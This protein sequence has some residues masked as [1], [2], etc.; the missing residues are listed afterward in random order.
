MRARN[1]T[2]GI[3]ALIAAAL[4]VRLGVWQM[5][6][7][8]ERRAKNA[9]L[10]ER[11]NAAPVPLA[12][13]ALDTAAARFRRVTVSGNLDYEHE[14]ALVG[15]ALNGSP[16]VYLVTPLRIDDDS[17]PSVLVNRGWVYSPDARVV[18]LTRWHEPSRVTVAGY[19]EE[20][21]ADRRAPSREA[22]AARSIRAMNPAVIAELVPYPVSPLYI[23]AQQVEPAV[24]EQPASARADHPVRLSLPEMD[25]GPHK[26]YAIQWFS[27]AVIALVG[28]STLIWHDMHKGRATTATGSAKG[29]PA[30]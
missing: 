3:L 11:L 20:F 21:A 17:T 8:A 6:R 10:A 24:R 23:V 15:R 19:L 4:F 2:A 16:G 7:L 18:D 27:F 9:L 12:S 5:H 25:E 29:S 13:V 22:M 14:F 26:S 28:V 1:V 30:G